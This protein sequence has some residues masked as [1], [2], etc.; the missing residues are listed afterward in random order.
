MQS[1]RGWTTTLGALTLLGLLLMHG[2]G[3]HAAHAAHDAGQH[4]AHGASAALTH[5]HDA[6]ATGAAVWSG[7]LGDCAGDGCASSAIAA[8]GPEPRSGGHGVVALCAAVL[9][10]LLAALLAALARRRPA[11]L[12]PARATRAGPPAR[13]RTTRARPDLHAL[14]VLRC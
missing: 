12:Q 5:G 3:G 7:A 13:A 6:L 4:G 2:F 1:G 14:S 11:L 8:P 9:L 10:A